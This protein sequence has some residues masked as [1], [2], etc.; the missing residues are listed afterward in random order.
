M[1]QPRTIT[2]L[3]VAHIPEDRQRD[4]LVLPFPSTTT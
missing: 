4:G 2:E 3:G 1:P